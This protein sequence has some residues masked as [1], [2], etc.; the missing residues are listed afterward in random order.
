MI[1]IEVLTPKQRLVKQECGH[2][3]V[4]GAN[5]YLG[6]L[7]GHTALVSALDSGELSFGAGV[8]QTPEKRFFVGGGYVQV[9]GQDVT[10][11]VDVAEPAEEID[12]ERAKKSAERA[13][14]R[15]DEKATGLD[16]ERAQRAL[17]RAERRLE[18]AGIHL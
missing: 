10:V 1:N 3:K 6:I 14:K 2:L 15:L 18:V 9:A 16:L 8:E 4:P 13:R 7:P 11:L 17:R 12:V 5:G